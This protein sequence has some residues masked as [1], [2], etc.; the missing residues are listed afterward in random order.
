MVFCPKGFTMF[1]T[2]LF[3]ALL[4]VFSLASCGASQIDEAPPSSERHNASTIEEDRTPLDEES[5][6]AEEP[7]PV[8]EVDESI[9]DEVVRYH[10]DDVPLDEDE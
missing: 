8:V 2:R 7:L 4:L 3:T 1:T 5:D 9:D 10:G 6:E